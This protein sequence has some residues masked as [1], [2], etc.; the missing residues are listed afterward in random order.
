MQLQ[1][2]LSHI[3][4]EALEQFADG[5]LEGAE[6]MSGFLVHISDARDFIMRLTLHERDNLEDQARAE[7]RTVEA[8]WNDAIAEPTHASAIKRVI[9]SQE[10][11]PIPG[12]SGYAVD[13]A[14]E[15]ADDGTTLVGPT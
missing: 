13:G 8:L 2:D 9:D 5:K 15:A 6:L 4:G 3:K 10:I 7:C 12:S 11:V 14:G 1:E